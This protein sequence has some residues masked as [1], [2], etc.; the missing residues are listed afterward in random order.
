MEDV[1]VDAASSLPREPAPDALRALV[2][3]P[4]SL[5]RR[6]FLGRATSALRDAGWDVSVAGAQRPDLD[7]VA[8]YKVAG[9][10]R[11][12]TRRLRQLAAVA[13][14]VL[15][16]PETLRTATRA[17]LRAPVAL[18]VDEELLGARA[19]G[20]R[21]ERVDV[22]IASS[23]AAAAPL[24][25][26]GIETVVI[27]PPLTPLVEVPRREPADIVGC[28]TRFDTGAGIDILLEAF[29]SLRRP[30]LQLQVV[31][32]DGAG[33]DALVAALHAR[34]ARP[35]LDGRVAFV[36]E[37]DDHRVLMQRWRV[38]VSP[39]V[40]TDGAS[41]PLRDAVA[42]GVPVVATDRGANAEFVGEH[43]V[44]VRPGRS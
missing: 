33:D 35:D 8:W 31:N 5:A 17:H 22:A 16:E 19:G 3:A 24:R 32:V 34:A 1:I 28:A 25:W 37:V 9:H 39:N 10:G 6:P 41:V 4:A 23:E 29:A 30:E 44:V 27:P 12:A 40:A 42:L 26:R 38:A 21:R 14:V 43:G 11:D 18:L 7:G 13:D 20:V 36:E 2:V 15:L